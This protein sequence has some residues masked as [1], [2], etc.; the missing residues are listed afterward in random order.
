MVAPSIDKYLGSLPTVLAPSEL[1]G[2]EGTPR[3]SADGPSPLSARQGANGGL[4]RYRCARAP[5]RAPISLHLL[6]QPR[7]RKSVQGY[8]DST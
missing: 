4:E 1:D 2:T 7:R 8:P 6:A 3:W 5:A